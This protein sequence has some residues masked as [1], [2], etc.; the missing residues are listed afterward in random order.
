MIS[1]DFSISAV[2]FPSLLAS[3][4]HPSDLFMENKKKPQNN[5]DGVGSVPSCNGLMFCAFY[6]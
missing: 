1:D 4:P 2:M 6:H 5:V 3:V